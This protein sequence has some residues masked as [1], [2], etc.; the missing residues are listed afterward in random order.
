MRGPAGGHRD[1]ERERET[2][3]ARRIAG[4]ENV[5]NKNYRIG[6]IS[7][8]EEEHSAAG[9]P[10]LVTECSQFGLG[11]T[12]SCLG[13]GTLSTGSHASNQ[14]RWTDQ[15]YAIGRKADDGDCS[16]LHFRNA[17]RDDTTTGA[18]YERRVVPGLGRSGRVS[19]DLR[20]PESAATGVCV[21]GIAETE[22]RRNDRGGNEEVDADL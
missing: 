11:V 14:Q 7:I 15:R 1:C 19:T 5:V 8:G 9:R 3:S 16:Q 17:S 2:Y 6:K 18:R 12:V 20:A 10:V 21:G 13:Y 4:A 22:R